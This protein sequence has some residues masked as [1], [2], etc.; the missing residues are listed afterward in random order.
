MFDS[1]TARYILRGLLSGVA[2][3]L[4]SLQ[5]SASGSDL[6]SG[7]VYQALIAGALVSLAYWG[8]GAAVPAVEPSIGNKMDDVP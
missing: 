2:A 4:V 1:V 6:N 3:L 8:I 5:A 7:E